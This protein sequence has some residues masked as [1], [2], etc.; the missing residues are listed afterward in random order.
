MT[1]AKRV[2]NITAGA[3]AEGQGRDCRLE[4][5]REFPVFNERHLFPGGRGGVRQSPAS[6]PIGAGLT[7]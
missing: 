7:M 5:A 4:P 3:I 2:T 6:I 1:R